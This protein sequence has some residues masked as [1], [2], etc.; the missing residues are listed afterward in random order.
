MARKSP[1][2]GKLVTLFGGSGFVGQHVA[3]GLLERGARVRI[4]ARHPETA[5]KLKPLANLGQLQFVRCNVLDQSSVA[6]AVNAADA[7]INCV[8]AFANQTALMGRAPGTI[9][10]AAAAAGAKAL[11]HISAVAADAESPAEYGRAKAMGEA[12]V[13]AA[14]PRATVLR[15]SLVF[16]EDDAFIN[17][18]AG[19]IQVMP[20]LPVFGPDAKLQPVFVDDVAE[21]VVTGLE[22]PGT[23]GGK[24]Y[25][26]GGP[27]VLTMLEIN[28]RI[29]A[30]QQRKRSFVP[31]P[32]T[33]S[34]LFAALPLT[35]MSSDQWLMLKAGD[36][37]RE[38]A[39]GLT[40]L[41]ITPKPLGLFL[42]RWMVRYREHGRFGVKRTAG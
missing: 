12:R 19:L 7:V 28:Q 39:A 27:E 5:F 34:A 17:M 21:A 36:V 13:L 31:V 29:A 18:F 23:H 40:R 8:G 20:V 32:D 26:L 24:T 25:E 11:V 16:G 38:G 41:G 9:A 14:F 30:A 4:A 2:D 6:A 37:V 15:P 33:L 3:Q 1:L 22:D 42:D 35:P 10:E